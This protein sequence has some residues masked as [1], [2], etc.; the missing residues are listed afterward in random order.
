MKTYERIECCNRDLLMDLLSD[1]EVAKVTTAQAA[2][3]IPDGD[4]YVDLEE[5]AK[6]VQRGSRL[7]TEVAMGDV[8]PRRAVLDA[9][10]LKIVELLKPV[11]TLSEPE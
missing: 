6:G 7:A 3:R 2:S 4:E 10:W 8:L 1:D 11:P 5:L 9:T